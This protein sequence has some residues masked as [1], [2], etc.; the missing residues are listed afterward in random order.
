MKKVLSVLLTLCILSTVFLSVPLSAGAAEVSE[1]VAAAGSDDGKVLYVL[2]DSIGEGFLE[3]SNYVDSW[4]KRLISVNGYKAD[5]NG[6]YKQKTMT[7]ANPEVSQM[8]GESGLGFVR[9][10][11]WS[12]YY[13]YFLDNTDFSYADIVIVA[14][15]INDWYSNYPI[16]TFFANMED[17]F[18]KIR[19]DNPDCELYYLLPFNAGFIGNY[20]SNYAINSRG[21]ND[22][23][24]T[25]GYTLRNF[26][27]LIKQ[28]FAEDPTFAAYNCHIIDMM[29]CESINR[30]TIRDGALYHKDNLHPTAETHIKIGDEIAPIL[31]GHAGNLTYHQAEFASC[32]NDGN[33]DYW[34]CDV[35][36]RAYSDAEGNNEIDP[37]SVII[38]AFGHN[39]G[40]DTDS[41]QWKNDSG[42]DALPSDPSDPSLMSCKMRFRCGTCYSTKVV[43]AAVSALSYQPAG[44]EDDGSVTYSATAT[45]ENAS[46]TVTKTYVI[47]ATGHMPS[48][49]D[50]LY[51]YV[52]KDANSGTLKQAYICTK[53]GERT[54]GNEIA[55]SHKAGMAP[56]CTAAGMYEY[57]QSGRGANRVYYKLESDLGSNIY[58]KVS[59]VADIRIPASHT[60][61]AH[62]AT[63]ATCTTA[64]NSAYYECSVCHK[65][66]S[67]E[68]GKTEITENSW[69]LPATGHTTTPHAA[70]AAT[71]TSAGNSAY[72]ECS[73]CHK[74]FSDENGTKEIAANSW[75]IPADGHRM[76]PHAAVAATC[77]A[78]GSSAYYE[79]SVCNKYFSDE[80]GKTEI[81]E[82]SWVINATGHSMTPHAAVA[83]T[84]TAAGSSAYYECSVCHKFFSDENGENEIAANSWVIPADGHSMTPH[85]AVPATCTT[86]GNS[87]YYE[88]TVCHKY[89]A[90][91]TGTVEIAENS[92]NVDALGHNMT[93]HEAVPATCDAEGNSAYWSCDR[94]NKFFSDA[95]GVTEIA[96]N[97][98]I[99]PVTDEH[100]Y[101]FDNGRWYW[102]G[103]DNIDFDNPYNVTGIHAELEAEC[104]VC[105]QV[106]Q[107]PAAV[108]VEYYRPSSSCLY[109][110]ELQYKAALLGYPDVVN[111]TS[112]I[113]TPKAAHEP[114]H[115][116]A[117]S[118][119]CTV[120]GNSEYWYCNSCGKYFSDENCTNVIQYADTVIPATGHS[121]TPHA[122]V[123]ATCTESGSSAYYECSVCHKFFSD[124]NGE[125]EIAA[126]SWVI[127]ADGHSMTPHAAVPA[128][129]TTAGNS[130][131][132]ECTACH[133]FFSDANGENEIAENSWITPATGVHTYGNPTWDWTGNDEDGYT[134]AEVTFTCSVCSDKETIP[135]SVKKSYTTESTVYTAKADFNG[136]VYSDEKSIS[137]QVFFTNHSLS[138]NGDIGVNFYLNLTDEQALGAKVIFSW[139]TKESEVPVNYINGSY[140]A[141]CNIAPA[142]MSYPISAALKLSG[143]D[144][145]I[146][147]DSYSVKQYAD[148]IMSDEFKASYTGTDSKSYDNLA[149]LVKAMLDYGA[150]AQ[151]R[152]DVDSDNPVND[153]N[154]TY[155][156]AVTPEM[157]PATR[158]NMNENLSDYGLEYTGSSVVLL[159]KTSIRHFYRIVDRSK[160]DAVKDGITFNGNRADYRVRGDEIY[161]ELANIGAPDIDKVYKLHIGTTDYSYAVTDYIRSIL[162]KTGESVNEETKALVS[163]MYHY[164]R[165]A[166]AYFNGS[167]VEPE[168]YEWVQTSQTVRSYLENANYS[169]SDYTK[170]VI[171]D[172]APA[173][174]SLDDERPAGY[175]FDIKQAGTLTVGD[176]SQQVEAGS[177][178]VYNVVPKSNT[179]FTV[180][181]NDGNVVQWGTLNPTHFLRQIK[182]ANSRN[183][184]DLGGWACDGGTVKYGKIIRGGA[185]TPED[186]EVLVNQLGIRTD[187]ELRS[188]LNVQSDFGGV[189]PT[190]SE[191]GEDINYHIYDN[192]AWYGFTR[193]ELCRQIIS[194][195]FESVKNGDPVYMHCHAG[196]DRTGTIAFILEAILGISQS[197]IDMDF[198]LTSFYVGGKNAR[199]RNNPEAYLNMVNQINANS[200][201]TFR[202]KAVKCV[203]DLGISIDEINAFRAAMI[204]GTPEILTVG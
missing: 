13:T 102:S 184:R 72:Y 91:A 47:P 35:C 70:V 51:E 25:Y 157:I 96:E 12:H 181:D 65:Y 5:P 117:S 85:A 80:N 15:G 69:V 189:I 98:W 1:D 21:D 177:F 120:A 151:L 110:G 172:Y 121:M 95:N 74:F 125:T 31:K 42:A 130:A 159:T 186:R 122:A 196:A 174:R 162:S 4:V 81:A 78:S 169:P 2:G 43:D 179:Q 195:I 198:E 28:K 64:G 197:D 168:R 75:V 199:C 175:T 183:M 143:N 133:K 118:A 202:D 84:C 30:D 61:T 146:A 7:P 67:D 41:E 114:D 66:F 52:V 49:D 29:E 112:N 17:V 136:Q 119:T 57:C 48:T 20:D 155:T 101:D 113:D 94:C 148:I 193:T 140:R 39:W 127:P 106:N 37:E 171:A 124:A 164:N 36:G 6:D 3:N 11:A 58:R 152:F 180:T 50:D 71:C 24:K 173:E 170:S 26:G 8:I 200:G 23:S 79:C 103:L 99:I 55:A 126:N 76:T 150:R 156:D 68:N 182:S 109:N 9:K 34:S 203:L 201:S 129:C 144:A 38:P 137:G 178:T 161:F 111:Y 14:L 138:L 82:N 56:T 100:H 90:D 108:T 115:H 142:E 44:C 32:E 165:I 153:G 166:D 204:D 132:Y 116:T 105:G 188:T 134:A 86:A 141:A 53:C 63:A 176:Y 54:Y 135:A 33:D 147:L 123:P 194:D 18:T 10:S 128:T 191:L 154:Y 158:S 16:D 92:W 97:S 22:L 107:F 190:S 149:A 19:T 145:P 59:G 192:Y 60:L 160:F 131:Y 62:P 77:T 73:V 88:C 27:N 187:V 83:A 89:F 93:P 45:L 139:Y 163:V 167:D 87:A 40:Y 185:V 46:K 104:T